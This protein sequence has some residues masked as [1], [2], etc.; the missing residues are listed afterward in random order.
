[1]MI[2]IVN[3]SENNLHKIDGI[4]V[5]NKFTYYYL[6]LIV[7]NIIEDCGNGTTTPCLRCKRS[8]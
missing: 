1:M 4:E 5:V 2:I 8:C 7:E 6:G 3:W